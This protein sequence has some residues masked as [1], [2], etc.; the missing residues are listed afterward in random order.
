MAH[1]YIRSHVLLHTY[2][3]GES[4]CKRVIDYKEIFYGM[5]RLAPHSTNPSVLR[6]LITPL[7]SSSSSLL[8]VGLMCLDEATVLTAD[9]SF[10]KLELQ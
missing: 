1:L 10:S 3:T 8:R 7:I 6:I 4:I 5:T 2:N 9:C